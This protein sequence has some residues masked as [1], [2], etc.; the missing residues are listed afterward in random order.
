MNIIQRI[1]G[2][3]IDINTT[4]VD[5]F[6]RW[7]VSHEKKFFHT[8]KKHERIEPDFFNLL[9][10]KLE[11]LR[12]GIY[13][14]AGMASNEKAELILTPDGNVTNV[15]FVEELVNSA[16]ELSRWKFTA[17]K[18]E[19][20]IENVQINMNKYLFD[21]HNISFYAIEH[22]DFPDEVDIAIVHEDMREDNRSTIVNGCYIF[23]DNL[24]GELRF[25]SEIDRISFV[26]KNEIKKELIPI[27]KLK[28]YLDWRIAEFREKYDDVTYH[29]SADR[30]EFL[31]ANDEKGKIDMAVVNTYLLDWEHKASHP[32]ILKITFDYDQSDGSEL[33][34]QEQY[35]LLEQFEHELSIALPPDEGV[36]YFGRTT[37]NGTRTIFLACKEFR[38]S[39]KTVFE[40]LASF[41]D[42]KGNY[43]IY[44]DKYWRTFESFRVIP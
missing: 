34:S 20:S 31:E 25:I 36:I 43:D 29:P 39:S 5:D 40:K 12:E 2:S 32:W 33:P 24:L 27:E 17:L 21:R 35:E 23:L 9:A 37:C 15:Y 3:T 13:F 44:K 41:N 8:V 1:F 22:H 18:P 14:L 26:T 6:W 7:F 42:L 30:Y 4:T 11:D 16:P 38:H 19:L 10:P 28:S